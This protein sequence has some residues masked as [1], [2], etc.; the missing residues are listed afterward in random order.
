MGACKDMSVH[1]WIC[2]YMQVAVGACK[3]QLVHAQK[4]VLA[5]FWTK[6]VADTPFL[7][8]LG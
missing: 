8:R 2:R 7:V 4:V 5:C 3:D 1:A 6:K